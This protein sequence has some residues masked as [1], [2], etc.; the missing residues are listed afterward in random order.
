M[1]FAKQ[2]ISGN[3]FLKKVT[4]IARKNWKQEEKIGC[5]MFENKYKSPSLRKDP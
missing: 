3:V 4:K 1:W 2:N 5:N